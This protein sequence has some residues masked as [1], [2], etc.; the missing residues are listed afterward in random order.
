VTNN[1]EIDTSVMVSDGAMLV[2][3]GLISDEVRETVRK[4]PALGDIP[5]LGNLFRYRRE[6]RTKRNLMVFLKPSI[7]RDEAL[8]SAIS[9]DKYN[10]IRARQLEKRIKPGFVLPDND[11]PLLPELPWST[12]LRLPEKAG[13]GQ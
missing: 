2:L 11:Q 1:R 7:L 3:G 8:E 10:F 6:D 5:V 13:G 12:P 9:S 4:V